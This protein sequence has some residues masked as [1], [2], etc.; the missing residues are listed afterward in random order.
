[1]TNVFMSLENETLELLDEQQMFALKGG[2]VD[3]REYNNKKTCDVKNSGKNCSVINNKGT[4]SLINDKSNTSCS[5]INDSKS[6][7]EIIEDPAPGP[8]TPT[9]N[10]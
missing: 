9:N 3:T 1:M 5:L 7:R 6:C 10:G 2:F 8:S 4:C